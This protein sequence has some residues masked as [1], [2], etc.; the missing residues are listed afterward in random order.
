MDVKELI[1]QLAEPKKSIEDILIN[2]ASD[3]NTEIVKF[4]LEAKVNPNPNVQSNRWTALIW[5]SD[6]G[7]TKIVKLLLEAKANPNIRNSYGN[8]ALRYAKNPE[9]KNLL[10]RAGAKT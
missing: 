9:I 3:G 2:A 4:L 8:T 6:N 10:I 1:C 7:H 5:A